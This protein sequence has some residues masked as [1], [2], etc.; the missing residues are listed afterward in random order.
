MCNRQGDGRVGNYLLLRREGDSGLLAADSIIG[1][2]F[3][4]VHGEQD[5]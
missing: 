3:G 5:R 2:R 4:P 1:L